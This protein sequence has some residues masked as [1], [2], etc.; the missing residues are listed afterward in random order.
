MDTVSE[1]I[2]QPWDYVWQMNVI[3]FFNLIAYRHDKREWEKE[4]TEKWKRT[5]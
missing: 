2:R 3:E 1:K 4:Q 5:H